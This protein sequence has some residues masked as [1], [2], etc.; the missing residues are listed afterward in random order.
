MVEVN[1][2]PRRIRAEKKA[3][4]P[5]KMPIT[6]LH[7]SV[8]TA[9]FESASSD[10]VNRDVTPKRPNAINPL[11]KISHLGDLPTPHVLY[12]V[13]ENDHAMAAPKLA[14]QPDDDD[15]KKLTLNDIKTYSMTLTCDQKKTYNNK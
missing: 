6:P 12:I 1:V 2:P 8:T 14:I 15:V 4:S 13:T 9:E 11:N 7:A 10:R 5:T 3:Q